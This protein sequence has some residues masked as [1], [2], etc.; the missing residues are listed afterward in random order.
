[1][2]ICLFISDA[3]IFLSF[4][5]RKISIKALSTNLVYAFLFDTVQA[6]LAIYLIVKYAGSYSIDRTLSRGEEKY[7]RMFLA[8]E[9]GGLHPK[10]IFVYLVIIMIYR[11]LFQMVYFENFGALVMIIVKMVDK[12]FRFL[13]ISTLFL[14]GFS[15]IGNTL[16]NDLTEFRNF[17]ISLNT[18]Y[19]SALGGFDFSIFAASSVTAEVYGRIFLAI[20]LLGFM[21]LILNFL[22][23]ILSETF[24]YYITTANA[25]KLKE[26]IKLRAIYEEHEHYHCL[27]KAPILVNFYMVFMAP[28]VVIFK[29]R[30]LNNIMLHVEFSIVAFVFA[31]ALIINM[32]ITSPLFTIIIIF[33]KLKGISSKAKGTLDTIIRI[34]DI[35]VVSLFI[36]LV[37]TIIYIG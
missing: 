18:M 36:P 35:F 8:T 31:V 4:I 21:I 11:M 12:S 33:I 25:L 16:F 22:I 15:L 32:I 29:S 23:A 2:M 20:Y 34:I 17:W 13:V 3:M 5:V 28:L 1:M 27:V 30:K 19:Q 7:Y 37:A 26:I 10:T 14:L 6:A 9:D 24:A